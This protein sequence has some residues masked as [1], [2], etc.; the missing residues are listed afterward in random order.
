[1]RIDNESLY[2]RIGEIVKKHNMIFVTYNDLESS[3]K[4]LNTIEEK[5]KNT[6]C[7]DIETSGF[8][9]AFDELLGIGIGLN[10]TR[11]IYINTR[12]WSKEDIIKVVNKIN[13]LPN[14]KVAHN[15]FFDRKFILGYIGID[16]LC[17]Y[18]TYTYAHVLFPDKQYYNESLSLKELAR[19]YTEYGDYEESLEEFKKD[20]CKVNKIKVKEFKYSMIPDS[21]LAPYCCMDTITTLNLFNKFE[22]I[23]RK[24]IE[25]GEWEK[26]REVIEIIHKANKYYIKASAEGLLVDV[27]KV[28]EINDELT[29]DQ[30]ILLAEILKLD[31]VK[32]ATISIKRNELIKAQAKRKS[33]LPLSRCRKLWKETQFKLSSSAHKIELFINQ[34]KLEPLEKT[35]KGAPKVDTAFINNYA[36][37]GIEVMTKIDE[38]LKNE[39]IIR[40]FLGVSDEEDEETEDKGLWKATRQGTYNRVH[41]NYNING[42]IT[43]R[44]ACSGGVNIQQYPS[45]G[46]AKIV[47]KCITVEDGYKIFAWD[48]SSFELRILGFIANEPSFKEAFDKDYDLHSLTAYNVFKD[49]MDLEST[50]LPDILKEIK[51]KYS[52]TFRYMSKAINFLIPYDGSATGLSKSLGT[53]RKEAQAMLDSYFDANRGI[54]EFMYNNKVKAR[55]IGYVENYFGTR[56]F[57][58]LTKSYD[59]ENQP[60]KKNYQALSEYRVT[61]NHQIQ[62][63]NSFYLYKCMDTFFTEIEQLGIDVSL[64]FTIYD[65]VVL[66]VKN[67]VDDL[68]L[69]D[70]VRKHFVKTYDDVTFEIDITRTPEGKN[71]WYDYAEVEL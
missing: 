7:L 68:Y 49:K 57:F 2:G 44:V 6:I 15:E 22:R 67:D 48:F 61:S 21:I 50:E 51:N 9:F 70:L 1:M 35:D 33:K 25:S 34:M 17:D 53:S 28:L 60:K 42:T 32:K 71:S 19:Q 56:M 24:Y 8:E 26:V 29:K 27:N 37:K 10:L 14:K 38:Y 65:S 30:E 23:V 45:R 40:A 36:E 5:V 46:K 4:A 12:G 47:K 63:F 11:S 18:C 54:K 64:M 39:K 3:I 41:P 31:E 43:S 59:F 69:K 16:L 13:E 20:Y 66:K 55:E 52:D 62:S 58:R